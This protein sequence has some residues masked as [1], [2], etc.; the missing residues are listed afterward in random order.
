[1]PARFSDVP[2]NKLLGLEVLRFTAAFAVLVWHYTHFAYVAGQ[3]ADIVRNHLPMY[4]LLWPFYDSG[5]HGV[6]LF[7]C[8]SGFIFFWKYRDAISDKSITGQ[9]FFV[10]RLSRLYPLHLATLLIVAALQPLYYHLQ[11][12]FFVYQGNDL[13]HFLPQLLMASNWGF[14]NG[15]TFNGPVWSISVEVLAYAV[16][17]LMLRFVG[18]SAWL[19]ILIIIC[20]IPGEQPI[21]G[22]LSFFYIGGLAAIARQAMQGL[23]FRNIIEATAW[24]VAGATPVLAWVFPISSPALLNYAVL[25][26]TPVL[27]F[28]F[29]GDLAV[30]APAST[31]IEAAGNMTYSS[32][33]LHFPI[34]LMILLGFTISGISIPFYNPMFFL[35]FITVTLMA[36]YLT[37]RHF[38]APAQN[39]IRGRLLSR[40]RAAP[41]TAAPAMVE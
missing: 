13:A 14:Q 6:W 21:F 16:F 22:C 19:N 29:A 28:C 4:G 25:L 18:K 11:G 41:A 3:P 38:E 9:V 33:L 17:F 34:Q 2:P 10:R 37:F 5:D 20:C 27:V 23:K 15:Y 26:Y 1:M 35:I 32:Y 24:L 40:S 12:Q 31:I 8:I 36:S 30:P 39:F 7:W